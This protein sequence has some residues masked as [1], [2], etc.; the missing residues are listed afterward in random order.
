MKPGQGVT[1]AKFADMCGVSRSAVNRHV[2]PGGLLCLAYAGGKIDTAHVDAV[3]YL[4]RHTSRVRKN[5]G[6]RG[7]PRKN[8]AVPFDGGAGVAL[9][10]R[11]AEVLDWPLRAI[12]EKYG[13]DE[14]FAR[15]VKAAKDIEM[16]RANQIKNEKAEGELVNYDLLDKTS[17]SALDTLFVR[18]LGDGCKTLSRRAYSMARSGEPA[19]E[20]E[21]YFIKRIS[22]EIDRFK[23][24]WMAGLDAAKK[25]AIAGG[26]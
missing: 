15:V 21:T 19:T 8:P 26:R 11:M 12:L 22:Q 5:A 10:D 14:E 18:L 2:R 24:S 7:R 23:K 1:Q 25:R 9:P 4:E 16:L 3:A 20:I 6:K 13:T 17:F